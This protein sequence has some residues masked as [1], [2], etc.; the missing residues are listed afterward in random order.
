MDSTP[1]TAMMVKVL[2]SFAQ[3]QDLNLPIKPIVFALA[4]GPTLGANGN[5]YGAS[6][7]I[8][9]ADV[10]AKLGHKITSTQYF[11]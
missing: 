2:D 11:R 6:S 4:F 9:C 7:N 5:L 1:V 10:A 3:N 8:L